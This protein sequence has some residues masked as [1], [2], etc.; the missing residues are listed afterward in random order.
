VT[1]NDSKEHIK[2]TLS[3]KRFR[4]KSLHKAEKVQVSDTTMLIIV[5][6]ADQKKLNKWQK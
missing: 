6:F 1:D 5:T 2:K 3:C 4:K